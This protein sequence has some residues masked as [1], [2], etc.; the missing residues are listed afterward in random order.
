MQRSTQVARTLTHTIN[1][2]L[3]WRQRDDLVRIYM[4][5]CGDHRLR[6]RVRVRVRVRAC[7]RV[8]RDRVY[9]EGKKVRTTTSAG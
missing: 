1:S 5:V 4:S 9:T 2:L 7:R 6:V 3:D 8:L